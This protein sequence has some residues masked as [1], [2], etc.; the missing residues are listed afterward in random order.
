MVWWHHWQWDPGGQSIYSLWN[1]TYCSITLLGR[2]YWEMDDYGIPKQLQADRLKHSRKDALLSACYSPITNR[3][4]PLCTQKGTVESWLTKGELERHW[5][6][7]S[8]QNEI[9]QA[10]QSQPCH[11]CDILRSLIS[12]SI[13]WDFSLHFHILLFS[14]VFSQL[15]Y[16]LFQ[17]IPF[18]RPFKE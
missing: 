12:W 7:S 8:S 10:K 13:L 18:V 11:A 3:A 16:K 2:I 9:C 4:E 17:G 15:R 6:K 1:N 14:F 5:T